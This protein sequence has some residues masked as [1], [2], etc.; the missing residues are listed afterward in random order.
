MM[1]CNSLWLR[2]LALA[3][4]ICLGLMLALAQGSPTTSVQVFLPSGAPPPGVVRLELLR[5]DG[6]VDTVFTDAKGK[7][8][9]HNPSTPSVNYT[10]TVQSDRLTYDTT[11]ASLTI[12]RNQP[13][14]LTIF[15][16]PLTAE[17]KSAEVLDVTNFEKN[18]P[19]KAGAAYKRAMGSV[20]AGKFENA[21][22]ELQQAI[23]LYPEYVRAYNDLGVIFMKLDRLDEAALT[24]KK[25]ADIS[26]RF[27]YPRMNLGLVLNRQE[28]F[29]EAVEVLEPLYQENHGMLEVRL[30]YAN[31]LSGAG[32]IVEA[33]K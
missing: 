29:K 32:Q 26:K 18:V 16:K 12:H 9:I 11:S 23:V 14:Y 30:A 31:A 15:L 24:F 4:L 21:I 1:G 33:E 22:T 13:T 17:R 25:A 7:F 19:Q 20:S 6:Y 8:G 10:V 28:K 27:F 5:E 2:V 3:I